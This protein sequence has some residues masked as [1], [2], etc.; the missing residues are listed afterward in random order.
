MHH[1]Q[2]GHPETAPETAPARDTACDTARDTAPGSAADS[3]P[4]PARRTV[5][6]GAAVAGVAGAAA[7][8]LAACGSA[9]PRTSVP[10]GPIDLGSPTEVPV[11]G[12]VVHREDRLVVTQPTKGEFRAFS[13]V[14]P[15]AGCVVDQVADGL[16]Q[17]PCHGSHFRVADGSVVEGPA[18]TALAEVPVRVE[19]GKLIAGS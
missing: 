19:D 15:H 10:R 16:I 4:C 12:G 17:C 14:C 13:A 2:S 8:G 3:A 1:P 11:G 9:R 6:R 5:L 7:L 18:P